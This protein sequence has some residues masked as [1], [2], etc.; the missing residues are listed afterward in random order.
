MAMTQREKQRRF[1]ARMLLK[2]AMQYLDD[3]YDLDVEVGGWDAVYILA[4]CEAK[5]IDA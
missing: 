2:H 3:H 4:V 5:L 1:E